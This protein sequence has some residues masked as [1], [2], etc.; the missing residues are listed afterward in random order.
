MAKA[1]KALLVK[2]VLV[3]FYISTVQGGAR[4][5]SRDKILELKKQLKS[6]NKPAV[7][8]IKTENGDIFDCV[9]IQKQPALDHPLLKNHIVQ[10]KPTFSQTEKATISS[11]KTRVVIG[12]PGGGCPEGTVP[13]KRVL[14]EDLIRAHSVV[15]LQ[16][17]EFLNQS[18]R[19][20]PYP[21]NHLSAHIATRPG[22]F[23]GANAVINIWEP[24]VLINPQDSSAQIR[25]IN[26]AQGPVN[27]IEAGWIVNP[28]FFNDSRV[29]LF[30]FWTADGNEKTGCFNNLCQG[31][32]QS[33]RWIPLGSQFLAHST[34]GGKQTEAKFSI[35]LDLIKNWWLFLNDWAIGYWPLNIFTQMGSADTIM[36]GGVAY[37]PN[38]AASMPEMGSGHWPSEGRRKACYMRNLHV[39]TPD[40]N[41]QDAPT[42]VHIHIDQPSCY[43]LADHGN[44]GPWRRHFYLGGPGGQCAS[45]G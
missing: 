35:K 13:I 12:L 31:F 23:Y 11:S 40:Y 5:L 28:A 45:E 44:R 9:D 1:F 25:L 37:N 43:S 14:M 6:L 29:R 42:D 30:G 2:T 20:V 7:K 27:V 21:S 10:T 4:I 15:G 34:Y 17:K 18:S 39:L 8:T 22:H 26:S 24:Q 19:E 36:W 41:L 38:S 33:H 3:W 32:V 16:K